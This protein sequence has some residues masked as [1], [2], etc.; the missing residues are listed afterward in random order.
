VRS[1][2]LLPRLTVVAFVSGLFCGQAC[3]F[4]SLDYLH[5]GTGLD[6]GS[7]DSRSSDNSP[8]QDL[9][10]LDGQTWD[11]PVALDLAVDTTP[12]AP[13]IDIASVR[14]DLGLDKAADRADVARD[15]WIAPDHALDISTPIFDVSPQ[16]SADDGAQGASEDTSPPLDLD[17][18]D[19]DVASDDALDSNGPI[20]T[21]GN[22]GSGGVVSSGGTFGFGGAGGK[23][24]T[25][26]NAG[27]S[28]GTV[29][30]P[31]PPTL[32]GAEC[33]LGALATLC[34]TAGSVCY[35]YC[36]FENLSYR[37]VTCSN[38]QLTTGPCTIPPTTNFACYS[39][40]S[41]TSCGA[42][43]PTSSTNCSVPSCQACGASTGTG[44]YDSNGTARAGYCVCSNGR[45]SCAS[46]TSW[47]CP[48]KTGC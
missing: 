13:A 35:T 10:V 24:S 46:P 26:G 44:Y 14:L 37:S 41:V 18:A 8:A 34:S 15:S 2:L 19:N 47:P 21:G 30:P 6:G 11:S 31:Q 5:N 16:D 29:T 3:S 36:G 1:V 27:G 42:S 38:G 43:P 7:R 9:G 48:G 33:T 25:G 28:S 4:R 32:P 45:W 17:D 12:D 40:D 39:L 22:D 20:S 23:T